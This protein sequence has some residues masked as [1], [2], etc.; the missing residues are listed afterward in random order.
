MLHT[1]VKLV[2][3]LCLHFG[4]CVCILFTYWSLRNLFMK[5]KLIALP[6]IHV[7]C[8][9]PETIIQLIFYN[10]VNQEYLSEQDGKSGMILTD[11]DSIESLLI[12]NNYSDGPKKSSINDY[13]FIIVGKYI[14]QSEFR[15]R[16]SN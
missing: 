14:S 11:G 2:L 3:P 9:V 10:E 1:V 15:M 4:I 16:S 8:L 13:G 12:L 7:I 5:S 6:V